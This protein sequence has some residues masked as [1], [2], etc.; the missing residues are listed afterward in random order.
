[1]II[2]YF[3]EHRSRREPLA[4]FSGKAVKGA[5]SRKEQHRGFAH[6]HRMFF[7]DAIMFDSF[8][9]RFPAFRLDLPSGTGGA[10]IVGRHLRQNSIAQTKWR[11]A[12][13]LEPKAFQQFVINRGAGD[14]D[15]G[16]AWT[17]AFNLAS[18]CD[19]QTSQ[20]FGD[21]AHLC[22]GHDVPLPASSSMQM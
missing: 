7:V 1:Y 17:D 3:V 11:I 18:L 8:E 5:E 21:A 20:A 22:S 12:K 6:V 4:I 13:P 19:G 2:A 10:V 14:D 9:D 16:A 15:F